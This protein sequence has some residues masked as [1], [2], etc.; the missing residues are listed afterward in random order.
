MAM[1]VIGRILGMFAVVLA[2]FMI[3][4]A[5][6]APAHNLLLGFI[7]IPIAALGFLFILRPDRRSSSQDVQK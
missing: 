6:M 7:A 4:F 1:L 5:I 3:F 2:V